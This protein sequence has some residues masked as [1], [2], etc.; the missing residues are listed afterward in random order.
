MP[1][2]CHSSLVTVIK[3]YEAAI[4][5]ILFLVCILFLIPDPPLIKINNILQT[6]AHGFFSSGMIKSLLKLYIVIGS[7]GNS[8]MARKTIMCV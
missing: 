3:S 5:T 7:I 2:I 4:Q 6:N 1:G 8:V